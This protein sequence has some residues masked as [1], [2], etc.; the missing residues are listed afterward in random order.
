MLLKLDLVVAIEVTPGG[1]PADVFAAHIMPR[2]PPDG[3]RLPRKGPWRILPKQHFSQF[4]LDVLELVSA[5]EEEFDRVRPTARTVE[6]Q[7]APSSSSSPNGESGRKP[8]SPERPR[9]P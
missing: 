8:V 3:E 6:G 7:I 4:H 5:I 2:R 1:K 9:A